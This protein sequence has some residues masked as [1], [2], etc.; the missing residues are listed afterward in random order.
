MPIT[1]PGSH[2]HSNSNSSS[3]PIDIAH[4]HLSWAEEPTSEPE[5]QEHEYNIHR[6]GEDLEGKVHELLTT[7]AN[8]Q[9]KEGMTE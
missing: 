3:P 4:S 2:E 7:I 5:N 9:P 1:K 8:F 6:P